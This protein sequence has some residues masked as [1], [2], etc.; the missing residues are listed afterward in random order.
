ME[1][2]SVYIFLIKIH[3]ESLLRFTVLMTFSYRFDNFF[4][5][6][7]PSRPSPPF[8]LTRYGG[9]LGTHLTEYVIG[10]IVC[11]KRKK[12]LCK[13]P[14]RKK[15][16]WQVGSEQIYF[17]FVKPFDLI[18]QECETRFKVSE[19]YQG[20]CESHFVFRC[21][22]LPFASQYLIDCF[23]KRVKFNCRL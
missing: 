15:E 2:C 11:M 1:L 4:K 21:C 10:N 5:Y 22:F 23:L 18:F 19:N 7:Q 14:Q 16:W 20:T 17:I 12:F 9:V 13:D 3:K 6:T 8:I